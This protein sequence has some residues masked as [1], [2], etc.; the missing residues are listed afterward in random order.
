MLILKYSER[1]KS[2]FNCSSIQSF[3]ILC[4]KGQALRVALQTLTAAHCVSYH[5]II[6]NTV[7]DFVP[8]GIFCNIVLRKGSITTN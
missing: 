4:C 6:N 2:K 7:K 3:V 5:F 1:N 8:F